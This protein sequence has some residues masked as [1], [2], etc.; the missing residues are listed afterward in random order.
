MGFI[1]ITGTL[2]N[3]FYVPKCVTI[4]AK[5]LKIVERI[6][7]RV[8]ISMVYMKNLWMSTILTSNTLFNYSSGLKDFSY[9]MTSFPF[10][11]F[12][13]A[14]R[15]TIF[16]PSPMG[17]GCL[18]GTT[19]ARTAFCHTNIRHRLSLAAVRA[20]TGAASFRCR[21]GWRSFVTRTTFFAGERHALLWGRSYLPVGPR[22]FHHAAQRAEFSELCSMPKVKDSA[23][24]TARPWNRE[25]F[26][27]QLRVASRPPLPRGT[28]LTSL[29]AKPLDILAGYK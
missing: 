5:V 17:L 13:T 1:T 27:D 8:L 7:R 9:Q 10:V 3:T 22:M 21:R 29:G 28:F 26:V 4:R 20:K 14:R 15:G 2:N 23:T 6:I 12:S 18:E 11:P 24:K 19:A 25:P 16:S